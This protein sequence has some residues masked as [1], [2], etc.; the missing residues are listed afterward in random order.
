LKV[1]RAATN[2]DCASEQ[3]P[4]GNAYSCL[5]TFQENPAWG[6]CLP[7]PTEC[8]PYDDMCPMGEHCDLISNQGQKGCIPDGTQQIGQ[9]CGANGGCQR[10][11]I[12]VNQ[13]CEIPCD[14]TNPMSCMDAEQTCSGELGFSDGTTLGFGICG[15][16]ACNPTTAAMDCA[17]GENCEITGTKFEC[18]PAGTA[19]AGATCTRGQTFCAVG[20]ICIN[21]LQGGMGDLCYEVCNTMDNMCSMGTCRVLMDQGGNPVGGVSGW[22]VCF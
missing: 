11:G 12:C 15:K 10:G 14:H 8:V 22:G 7:T 20:S 6:L 18:V 9:P 1:C 13:K 2:L 19:M 3:D 17:M 16:S 21:N 4:M 5:F